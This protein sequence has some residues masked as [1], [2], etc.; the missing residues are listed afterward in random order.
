MYGHVWN[1]TKFVNSRFLHDS[2]Y[3]RLRSV[4]LGYNFS[5]ALLSKIN[6]KSL[7]LYVQADNLG[8]FTLWPYLDPEV[9]Y[10][11]NAT[12]YGVDWLDPGQPR[13]FLFGVNLKF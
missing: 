11:S 1:S 2:S 7:R 5:P 6:I 13:T 10:N 12:N 3:L 4:T 8:L 9:S